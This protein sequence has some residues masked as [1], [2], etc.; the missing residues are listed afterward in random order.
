MELIETDEISDFD[1]VKLLNFY[2]Q[3][4][5]AVFDNRPRDVSVFELKSSD[6]AATAADNFEH[7]VR[8][9]PKKPLANSRQHIERHQKR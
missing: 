5:K 7:L 8:S 6:A 9:F 2:L 1:K 4:Y 3:R